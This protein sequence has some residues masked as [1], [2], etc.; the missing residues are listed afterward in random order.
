[1]RPPSRERIDA[2]RDLGARFPE[3][4]LR[5]CAVV[6][7][8]ELGV[9]LAIESLQVTG[10]F[11]IRG[12]LVAVSERKARGVDRVIS[13]SAGN[14]GAGLAYACRVLGVRA[15]VYVPRTAAKAKQKKIAS[16]GADLHVLDT[17]S[18]DDAEATAI[19]VAERERVP[20]LSAYDDEDIVLGNGTSLG[21]E[22]AAAVGRV[23]DAVI[24][25]FGGGGLA[26]G[27]AWAFGKKNVWGVE[28]EASPSMSMSLA[29]GAAVTRLD[30]TM[31]TVAE[32]LEGGITASAFD[33]AARAI[34][35]VAVVSEEA[36]ERAMAF[37]IRKL[38]IV[39]EGSG[40]AALVPPIAGL[41]REMQ[42]NDVVV[43]LT[44][45]N[46]DDDRIARVLSSHP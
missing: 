25:P 4:K 29:R 26:S 12:A 6:H 30:A 8:R 11:K 45:R 15:T 2:V 21:H 38:G 46:V 39:V 1:M 22:I 19:E 14:H 41:P 31:P 24:A 16:Y 23:P 5:T 32:G 7:A 34:A 36:I 33:R 13:V 40:A 3:A 44:G 10:S 9:W 28:S 18:Y 35:G 17:D 20:F 37:A 27:L 43:V 42:G